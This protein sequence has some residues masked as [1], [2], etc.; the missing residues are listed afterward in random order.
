MFNIEQRVP[1]KHLDWTRG[2]VQDPAYLVCTACVLRGL[3][4]LERD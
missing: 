2:I 4:K 1:A 3:R